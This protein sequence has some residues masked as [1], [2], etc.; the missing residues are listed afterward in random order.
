ME[1]G[2]NVVLIGLARV[3]EDVENDENSVS[4]YG[5]EYT[6]EFSTTWLGWKFGF[7]QW[8]EGGELMNFG[9]KAM[10]DQ[11]MEFPQAMMIQAVF[12]RCT[13]K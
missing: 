4:Y 6:Y 11:E 5:P 8:N 3:A 7:D 9:A 1:K 10:R 13:D 2:A 12:L